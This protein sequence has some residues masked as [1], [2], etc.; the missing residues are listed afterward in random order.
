MDV[1]AER[2]ASIISVGLKD[3]IDA[4]GRDQMMIFPVIVL[5]V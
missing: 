4:V 2:S 1:T 5:Q 3:V